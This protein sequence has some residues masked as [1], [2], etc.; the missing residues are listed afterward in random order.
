MADAEVKNFDSPDE[1][2]APLK[3]KARPRGLRGQR[4]RKGD[5]QSGL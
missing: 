5:W 3:A 2:H 4:S 1:T